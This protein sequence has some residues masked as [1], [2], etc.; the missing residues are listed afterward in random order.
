MAVLSLAI[1][2]RTS[3]VSV[4]ATLRSM[5]CIY[6]F[7]FYNDEDGVTVSKSKQVLD[8]QHKMLSCN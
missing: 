7:G 6:I 1:L 4:L 3:Q 8:A 2:D 5:A